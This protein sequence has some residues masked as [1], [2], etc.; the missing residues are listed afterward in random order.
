MILTRRT[1]TQTLA[2]W[3]GAALLL[4]LTCCTKKQTVLD[5][6][7]I[8]ALPVSRGYGNLLATVPAI[9]ATGLDSGANPVMNFFTAQGGRG[10]EGTVQI[11][12]R[13]VSV[14]RLIADLTRETRAEL[15]SLLSGRHALQARVARGEGA[16]DFL[17][18]DCHEIRQ[19]AI[20]DVAPATSH[21][22]RVGRVDFERRGAA[23]NVVG[24]AALAMP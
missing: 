14:E 6:S 1:F 19:A 12:G 11:D 2:L 10:N 15:A 16:Y 3:I 18:A 24:A 17:A 4:A 22:G 21:L 23:L 13:S 20:D 9:Q 5:D 8:T 7:V